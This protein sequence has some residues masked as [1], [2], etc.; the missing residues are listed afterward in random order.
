LNPVTDGAEGAAAPENENASV[1]K[2]NVNG[3]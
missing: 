1:K 2:L 3:V